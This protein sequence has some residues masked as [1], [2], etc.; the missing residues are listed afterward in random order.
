MNTISGQDC[1][2]SNFIL[3]GKW[4]L[5]SIKEQPISSE[6]FTQGTPYIEIKN[7]DQ[8]MSG[9]TGCNVIQGQIEIFGN[10]LKFEQIISTKRYCEGIS[11]LVFLENLEQVD[12]YILEGNILFMLSNETRLLKFIKNEK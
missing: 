8:I 12:T 2:E 1:E 10:K 5:I 6:T 9:F 4:K 7:K 3:V 11:E